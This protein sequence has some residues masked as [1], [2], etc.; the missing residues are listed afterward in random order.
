MH[1]FNRCRAGLRRVAVCLALFATAASA[2]TLATTDTA[3]TDAGSARQG[4]RYHEIGDL[5]AVRPAPVRPGL[6]LLG[7]GDRPHDAFRWFIERAGHGRIVILRASNSVDV[8]EEFF[9][10]VG[11]ITAAQTLVFSD[12]R[13][14]S[15][16]RVLQIVHDADGLFLAGGDQ[17][18]Y[19]R[20]WKGTPLNAAID[21]HVKQGKPLGGTSAGLAILGTYAYGAMDG[22]SIV[23]SEALADPAGPALTLVGDFLHLPYLARVVTDSHFDERGRQGRLV[24]FLARLMHEKQRADLVGLGVDES[25]GLCI[26]GDGVGRVF[27]GTNGHVWLLQP[28]RP[29]DVY[30]AGKPLSVR[31]VRVT[32][33]G[34]DSVLHLDDL[35]V[36]R[37]AFSFSYDVDAGRL[38]RRETGDQAPAPTNGPE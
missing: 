31:D 32:G 38:Q 33:I 10:E 30:A 34:T 26:D 20:F 8:Q 1:A 2:A 22:G 24:A 25:A 6:M 14:A 13:A 15:D 35:R 29:A 19:V 27:S 5:A 16:P 9:N 18:N 28:Q 7:G 12:R 4:Y 37:P 21:A 23:S 3:A 36:E 11:G 17:S